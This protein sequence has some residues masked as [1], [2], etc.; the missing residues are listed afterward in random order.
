[1]QED[2]GGNF[3]SISDEDGNEFELEL[4]SAMDY[5]GEEYRLFLPADMEED[6]PDYGFIILQVVEENGEELLCDVD[7]QNLLQTVYEAFMEVLF[8]E[9]EEEPEEE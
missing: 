4:I 8:A 3:V 7:D 9:E 2:F 1:M 6:D 5:E